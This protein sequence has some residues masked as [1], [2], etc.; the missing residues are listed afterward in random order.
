MTTDD[1]TE[2][3]QALAG[4]DSLVNNIT[5]AATTGGQQLDTPAAQL[6][7]QLGCVAKSI[8][9]LTNF[10]LESQPALLAA[11]ADAGAAHAEWAHS[12]A[13]P[14]QGDFGPPPEQCSFCTRPAADLPTA[15]WP[16][17]ANCFNEFGAF[18]P[19]LDGAALEIAEGIIR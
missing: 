6:T 4:L 1:R 14:L 2:F 7:A 15:D 13:C 17:C 18:D 3:T 11:L 10:L 5:N 19:V 16:M 8:N 12:L 9:L